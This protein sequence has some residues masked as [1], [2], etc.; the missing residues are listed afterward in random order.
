MDLW[1]YELQVFIWEVMMRYMMQI[2]TKFSSDLAENHQIHRIKH[3]HFF[4]IPI[5]CIY[6]MEHL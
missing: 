1:T 6:T 3:K 2:Y 4:S 5:A